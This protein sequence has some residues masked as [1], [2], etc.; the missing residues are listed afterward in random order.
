MANLKLKSIILSITILS[1]ILLLSSCTWK[2]NETISWENN[3]WEN[4][5]SND[6]KDLWGIEIEEEIWSAQWDNLEM[7]IDEELEWSEEEIKD[8]EKINEMWWEETTS[9]ETAMSKWAY[10]DYS[11]ELLENTQGS[12]VLFFHATWCPTCRAADNNLVSSDAPDWL[13]VFKVDYDSNNDL[14]NKYW[15]S[16]QHTFVEVD[17]KWNLISKWSWSNTYED[18]IKSL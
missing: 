14:R 17:N 8:I 1:A 12:I 6:S 2:S 10:L 3:V 15:V 13:T 18:I 7:T 5:V 16:S 4:I 11:D 9:S